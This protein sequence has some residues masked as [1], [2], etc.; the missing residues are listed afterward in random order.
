LKPTRGRFT[1]RGHYGIYSWS[2]T[3]CSNGRGI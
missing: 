2:S 3:D 1:T